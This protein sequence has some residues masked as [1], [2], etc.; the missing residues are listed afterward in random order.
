MAASGLFHSVLSVLLA[1]VQLLLLKG[2]LTLMTLG[3][4]PQTP[5]SV[6]KLASSCLGCRGLAELSLSGR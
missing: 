2:K 6:I 4:R 3:L 5:L 1:V